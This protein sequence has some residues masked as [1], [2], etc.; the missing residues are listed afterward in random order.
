MFAPLLPHLEGYRVI[1]PDLRAHGDSEVPASRWTIADLAR[2][3]RAVLQVLEAGPALVAGFSMGG[4]AALH[5]ALESPGPVRGL[6]LLGTSAEGESAVRKA[7]L[8]SVLGLSRLGWPLGHIGREAAHWMFSREFREDHPEIVEAWSREVA[9]MSRKALIQALEAVGRRPSVMKRLP[10]LTLP[11]IVGAGE[12]D[13]V[14]APRH[15]RRLARLLPDATLHL[16]PGVGHALPIEAPEET[17]GLIRELD[18][19]A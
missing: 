11:V 13:V 6:V 8:I 14:L 4:M 9:R 16:V 12:Q 19:R 7:Q 5:M 18:G 15:S 17:A 10:R 1:A 2:D 3:C